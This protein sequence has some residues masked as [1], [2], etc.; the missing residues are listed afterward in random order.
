MA[1]DGSLSEAF[2]V[3]PLA[4][5][6]RFPTSLTILPK[7]TAILSADSSI[8]FSIFDF[9]A[10]QNVSATLF[11]LAGQVSSS[12]STFSQGVSNFFITDTVTARV[13]E[14][15]VDA[16]VSA[17]IVKVGSIEVHEVFWLMFLCA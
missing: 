16:N 13:T 4:E 12:R 5:G 10:G 11:T 7:T 6:G 9:A 8:G 3:V 1:V 14:V 15:N 2:T 17:T